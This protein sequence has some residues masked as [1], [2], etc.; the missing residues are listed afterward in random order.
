MDKRLIFFISSKYAEYGLFFLATIFFAKS[1]GKVEYGN[2]AL[3]FTAISYA[4]FFLLGTNQLTLRN[5]TVEKDKSLVLRQSFLLFTT[6]LCFSLLFCV[7]STDRL[8]LAVLIIVTLK[9]LNEYLMTIAR[10]L[11][12]YN[13]LSFCYVATASV[14]LGYLVFL[15]RENFFYVWPIALFTPFFITC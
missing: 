9:L 10:G 4:P 13:L 12:Q 5:I 2:Y 3:V 11:K 7:F 6:L 8:H 15:D 1:I 14:W